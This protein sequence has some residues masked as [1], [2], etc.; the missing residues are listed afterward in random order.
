MAA[1][2]LPASLQSFFA[3]SGSFTLSLAGA[4]EQM[5]KD[6]LMSQ[7]SICGA[8]GLCELAFLWLRNIPVTGKTVLSG[9][10]E[11]QY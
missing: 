8:F 10:I 1:A 3:K 5:A 4:A 11:R 2:L 7:L 6:M 9:F